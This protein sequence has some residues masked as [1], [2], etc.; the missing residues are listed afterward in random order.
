[1]PQRIEYIDVAKGV[2]MVLVVVGHTIQGKSLGGLAIWSFH[3]PLFFILSGLC[4]NDTRWP[5]FIPFLRRR[6]KTLAVPLLIFSVLVHCANCM[7]GMV[8]YSIT[9]INK[10]CLPVAGW[11]VLVL[12]FVE[13][14]YWA[15]NKAIVITPPLCKVLTISVF[16]ALSIL[17]Y[18]TEINIP[19]NFT[20]IPIGIFF[21][22]IGHQARPH[23][24]N[25]TEKSSS[26][27]LSLLFIASPIAIAWTTHKSLDLSNN[28]IPSPIVLRTVC[29]YLATTGI[30][31]LGKRYA[32]ISSQS[33]KS[34]RIILWIGRNT[35]PILLLHMFLIS[36][37]SHFF[38]PYFISRVLYKVIEITFVTTMLYISVCLINSKARWMIG[39]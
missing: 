22:S 23:I 13:L 30:L 18:R 28:Y 8:D 39:K 27:W 31:S 11:F 38:A 19:F 29:A 34:K 10:F 12:F 2:G 14:I 17:I 25:I 36:F 33:A 5:M 16:L 1:M 35:L 4:F 9:D 20:S 21:Y 3:M 26:V 24:T 7:F 37:S 15:V 6:I 32:E